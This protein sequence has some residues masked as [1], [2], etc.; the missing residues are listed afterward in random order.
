MTVLVLVHVPGSVHEYDDEHVDGYG[1]GHGDM[2]DYPRAA[3]RVPLPRG[4]RR[5]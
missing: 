1:N 5:E 4:A 3:G 2:S